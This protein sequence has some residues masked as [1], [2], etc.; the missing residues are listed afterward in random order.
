MKQNQ[1][2]PN[3]SLSKEG[4]LQGGEY[5]NDDTTKKPKGKKA[6]LLF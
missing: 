4:S 1:T 2:T 6:P 3:P 5:I